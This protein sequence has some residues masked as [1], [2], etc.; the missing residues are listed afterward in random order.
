MSR[1]GDEDASPWG[2]YDDPTRVTV[3]REESL[4]YGSKRYW[5]EWRKLK[6]DRPD[7]IQQCRP[8]QIHFN[9]PYQTDSNN[10]V[11]RT[12][13]KVSITVDSVFTNLLTIHSLA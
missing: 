13:H 12:I 11:N 9:D 2:P 8:D 10:K 5:E 6:N 3:P 7:I 4:Q 1:S